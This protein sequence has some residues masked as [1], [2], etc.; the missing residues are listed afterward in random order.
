MTSVA[1]QRPSGRE[2]LQPYKLSNFDFVTESFTLMAGKRSS[3][4]AAMTY[5]LWTPVVVSSDTPIMRSASLV[6]FVGCL[7]NSRARRAR[8]ILNSALSV[9]SG[10][11]RV[12]LAAYAFSALTPSWIRR[13]M[14][15]PSS[16]IRSHPSPFASS[17]HV[18]ALRVHSQYSSRVSPFQAKTAA[19]PSRA[20]A[21]A[22]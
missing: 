1:L 16:T 17:G 15:P 21:A 18:M 4:L 10:S 20:T 19:E 2:C 5:N 6:H 11:G 12:L 7:G 14:S 3:P 8:T 22:A 9:D 13:V